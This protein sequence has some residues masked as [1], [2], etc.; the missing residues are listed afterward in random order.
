MNLSEWAKHSDAIE[1][2]R[3]GE[4]RGL[5]S[6]AIEWAIKNDRLE[7]DELDYALARVFFT[8]GNGNA[9]AC[10]TNRAIEIIL[11]AYLNEHRQE[12]A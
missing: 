5:V 8:G 6:R 7:M 10:E 4:N 1:D 11:D 9:P 2:A 12:A 3:D